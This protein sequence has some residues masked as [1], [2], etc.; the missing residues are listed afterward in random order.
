MDDSLLE[1]LVCPACREKVRIDGDG[2][3]CDACRLRYPIKDG[4]PV[5]IAEEA[6]RLEADGNADDES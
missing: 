4:I 1:I 6:T 2:L 3:I 5:M